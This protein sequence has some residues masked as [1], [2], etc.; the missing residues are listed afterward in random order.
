M[1]D[2]SD[3]KNAQLR[4]ERG[5]GFQEIIFHIEQGDVLAVSEHPN[6][7]KFLEQKII[8]VRIEDYVYMVPFVESEEG[9]F[10]KTII[11][12]RKATKKLL[13]GKSDET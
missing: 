11:P 9:K 1:F 7:E 6:K 10:L 12:S 2:W 3:E 5:I 4:Q 13:G 8:Y